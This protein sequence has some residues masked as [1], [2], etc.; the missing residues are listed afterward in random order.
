MTI[1]NSYVKLP[2][3]NVCE[4]D[5]RGSFFCDLQSDVVDFTRWTNHIL[6]GKSQKSM[7]IPIV[8]VTNQS[9]NS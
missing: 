9:Y 5:P 6:S 7:E 4:I 2:E 8:S 3:G 1:F